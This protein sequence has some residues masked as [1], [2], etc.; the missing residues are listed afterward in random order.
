V[1]RVPGCWLTSIEF[2]T[3]ACIIKLFM[4]VIVAV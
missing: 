1:N 3:V 2:Y 4:A